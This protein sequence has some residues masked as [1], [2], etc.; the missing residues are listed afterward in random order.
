MAAQ[1]DAATRWLGAW[2]GAL[3]YRLDGLTRRG[4]LQDLAVLTGREDRPDEVERT[5]RNA[6]RVNTVAVLEVLSMVD[7]KL[8]AKPREA[9]ERYHVPPELAGSVRIINTLTAV[10]AASMRE[11]LDEILSCKRLVSTSLHGMVFA[12]SYGIPCLYFSPRGTPESR[13]ARPTSRSLPKLSEVSMW[14]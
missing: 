2:L 14:R 1:P 11:K 6:Y 9:Y 8:D 7:R 12:E 3:H 13:M 4:C 5:L 10:S